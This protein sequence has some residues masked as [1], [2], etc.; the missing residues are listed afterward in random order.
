MKYTLIFTLL[1]VSLLTSAQNTSEKNQNS[2]LFELGKGL[3]ID[4]DNGNYAFN[5]G[6]MVQ[7][8]IGLAKDSSAQSDYFMNSKRTYFHI[9]GNAKNEHVAFFIQTD[10]SLSAPLLD[11]WVSYQPHKSTTI[12]F[13]QK[14]TIA[15]NREM[16]L[17]EDKLQFIDRS[18]LSSSYSVIGREFGLFLATELPF[19]KMIL[20]PQIAITSGDGRNSFGVDSRDVDLGG[21]KYAARLDFYPLGQF[22]DEN[23]KQI[24][25][26]AHESKLKMVLGMA[27]SYNDGASD[28]V[29]EGHGNLALYNLLRQAQLPDY[30]KVYTDLLLKYKGF[31]F[32]GE[33]AIGTAKGLQGAYLNANALFRLLPTQISQFLALGTGLNTQLGYVTASG[34]GADVRL[35]SVSPEFD[36]NSGSVI[37]RKSAITLGL[38][39]YVKNNS[40]K[41]HA[42]VTSLDQGDYNT[43]QAVFMVQ[44]VF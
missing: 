44:V 35:A 4:F 15:N 32:L 38:T 24:M 12:T 41:L 31:S 30:R 21:L 33:Y 13:G 42:A 22:S 7:P 23:D 20:I 9:G 11:A 3:T 37:Q 39:K 14:Q 27:G 2:A 25:D 1:T 10:F 8:S 28:V 6:G 18:L 26:L 29:G 17:M 43:I 34:Y 40:L 19:K 16:L 5:L 36:T